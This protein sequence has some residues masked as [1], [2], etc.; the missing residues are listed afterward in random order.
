VAA[1]QGEGATGADGDGK[2]GAAGNGEG[3][4]EVEAEGEAGKLGEIPTRGDR[5]QEPEPRSRGDRH[6][7]GREQRSAGAAGGEEAERGGTDHD[8]EAEGEQTR[9]ELDRHAGG[10]EGESKQ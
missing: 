10:D 1:A 6:P 4:G 5:S 8:K 9:G 2:G 7:D 3:E